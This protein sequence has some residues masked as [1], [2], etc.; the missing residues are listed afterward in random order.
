MLLV[1]TDLKQGLTEPY[2]LFY[3]DY[4]V[5]SSFFFIIGVNVAN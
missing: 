3:Y 2:I 5:L 1:F 4:Y